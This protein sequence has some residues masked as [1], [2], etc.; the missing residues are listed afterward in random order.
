MKLR[1]ARVTQGLRVEEV[2]KEIHI[3]EETLRRWER[4][5]TNPPAHKLLALSE[6]Y[7]RDPHWLLSKSAMVR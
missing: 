4:G 1:D 2:A 3:S 5:T 6:L 7:N